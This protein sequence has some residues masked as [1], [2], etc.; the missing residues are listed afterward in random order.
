MVTGSGW[1]ES[2]V[3]AAA[4]VS[5]NGSVGDTWDSAGYG[6]GYRYGFVTAMTC[7]AV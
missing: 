2:V 6:L 3:R 1:D 4:A 7:T 5:G